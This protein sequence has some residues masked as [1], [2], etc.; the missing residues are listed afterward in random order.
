MT[1]VL[2]F[3]FPKVGRFALCAALLSVLFSL[4]G[5]T[6]KKTTSAP[7]GNV[8]EQ[9]VDGKPEKPK[10][11]ESASTGRGK[12]ERIDPASSSVLWNVRWERAN[13]SFGQKGAFFGQMATVSGEVFQNGKKI[14]T[15]KAE[16]GIA[17]EKSN[18]LTLRGKVQFHSIAYKSDLFAEEVQYRPDQEVL[19]AKGNVTVEGTRGYLGPLDALTATSDLRVLGTPD[20]MQRFLANRPKSKLEGSVKRPTVQTDKQSNP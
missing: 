9:K 16:A 13:L 19:E 20:S 12:G 6:A 1:T 15:Y 4:S 8:G 5:C 17:D 3:A 2:G 14:G 7:K 18:K 11:I 10:L